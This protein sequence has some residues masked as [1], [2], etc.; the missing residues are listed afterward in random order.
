MKNVFKKIILLLISFTIFA[1]QKNTDTV[2]LH[3]TGIENIAYEQLC[4][5][6]DDQY[7]FLLYIGRDDCSDCIEFTPYLQDYLDQHENTG[8]Y[9]LNIKE[10]RDASRKE[11]ATDE[12]KQFFK[13]L[14]KELDF[15]WTPTI[16]IIQN[17]EIISKYQY[18]SE[19]YYTIED[20]EKRESEKDQY[21][22]DFTTYMN[23]YFKKY[24]AE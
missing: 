19:E 6:L 13:N 5:Y 15:D 17:G 16:E 14:Y 21:L 22:E 20:D 9:Y 7:T 23:N 2:V 1:C 12:E 4:T 10:Y 8:I 3:P 24:G 11:D 18:L